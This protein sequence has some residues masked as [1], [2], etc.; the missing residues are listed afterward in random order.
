MQI[1]SVGQSGA[2]LLQ[3]AQQQAS[4]SGQAI[5]QAT[6][7]RMASDTDGDSQQ[8]NASAEPREQNANQ[9]NNAFVGLNQ[10]E[11]YN[12]IGVKVLQ[13]E[14]ATLGNLLDMKA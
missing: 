3:Q 5:A 9:F 7:Y 2:G 10:A 11:N 6:G 14:D 4:Q 8:V 1:P 13:A 12:R